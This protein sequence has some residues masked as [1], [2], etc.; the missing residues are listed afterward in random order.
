MRCGF[1]RGNSFGTSVNEYLRS[2][3]FKVFTGNRFLLIVI[4]CFSKWVE[5]FPLQN[6]RAKMIADTFVEQV[7]SRHGVS[8]ELRTDQC[9]NFK[10]RLFKKIEGIRKTR[11]RVCIGS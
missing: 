5:V 7:V 4:D 2:F 11:T 10:S 6:F 3:F 9:S 8:M 1:K